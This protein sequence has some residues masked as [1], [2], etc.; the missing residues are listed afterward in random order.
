MLPLNPRKYESAI[1][2][3]D[4]GSRNGT[5]WVCFK[6]VDK[7]VYYYD[8]FGSLPPPPELKQYFSD[9]EIYYNYNREQN[10]NSVIC[11]HLCL[12]FLS[13]NVLS[14]RDN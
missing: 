1:V 6:K 2:N 7:K 14:H 5:H 13:G 10:Y 3:L 9:C 12:K 4:S 11:G 8:S